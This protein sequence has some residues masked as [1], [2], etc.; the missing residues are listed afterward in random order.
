VKQYNIFGLIDQIEYV[1]NQF[2]IIKRMIPKTQKDEI[3]LH[4]ITYRTI[5]SYE[6]IKMYNITRLA[7]KIYQLRK[8]GFNITS[9][10]KKFTNKYGNTSNYSIYKFAG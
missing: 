9:T 4:L 6:A 10:L 3:L 1:E 2:K 8:E 5:T 7:D